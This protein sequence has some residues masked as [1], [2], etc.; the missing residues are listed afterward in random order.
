MGNRWW[1][2]SLAIDIEIEDEQ[3]G[4]FGA[5]AAS[6]GADQPRLIGSDSPN[7]TTTTAAFQHHQIT[8]K[9]TCMETREGASVG[10]GT[11]QQQQKKEENL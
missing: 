4:L 7:D 6:D 9:F 3:L 8:D 11:Q 5:I 2:I 1:G 10:V